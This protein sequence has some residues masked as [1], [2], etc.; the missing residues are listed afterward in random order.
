MTDK[1]HPVQLNDLRDGRL[2][3]VVT[4]RA[5]EVYEELYGA[6]PAII[7]GDC[8]G[9]FGVGEIIALLY[10]RSFPRA[11]WQRRFVDAIRREPGIDR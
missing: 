6:Q 1:F 10:A 4:L 7:E 3:K 5:Y 9:G 8:R 2:P 11:E